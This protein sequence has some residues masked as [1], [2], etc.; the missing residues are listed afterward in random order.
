[1][2]QQ[3]NIWVFDNKKKPTQSRKSKSIGENTYEY[4]LYKL[5]ITIIIIT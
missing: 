2:K 4:I 5:C 1:M 3:R